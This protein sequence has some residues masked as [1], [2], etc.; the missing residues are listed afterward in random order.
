MSKLCWIS[1]SER[2]PDVGQIVGICIED[3]GRAEQMF[4][5]HDGDRWL[6]EDGIEALVHRVTA[7]V[8]IRVFVC[9]HCGHTGHPNTLSSQRITLARCQCHHCANEFLIAEDKP[10]RLADYLRMNPPVS[11]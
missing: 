6:D 2:L 5:C 9:P 10:L 3:S 4:G 11:L 7:W 8:L 1:T